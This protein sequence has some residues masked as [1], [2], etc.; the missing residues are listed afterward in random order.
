MNIMENNKVSFYQQVAQNL[1]EQLKQGTAPW[2]RAWDAAAPGTYLPMN[3][4]SGQRYR[5]IN[6]VQLLM[7]NRNDP[8]WLTYQQAAGQGGQVRKGEKGT[9]I[10]YWKF[11]EEK[12]QLDKQGKPVVDV[13]GNPIKEKI[14][15]ERPQV[16]YATV[17]NAEQIE[18]LRPLEKK[19]ERWDSQTKAESLLQASNATL[20]HSPLNG[21]YYHTATDRIYLP[22]KNQFPTVAHYYATALH[23][24]GH[25]T[26]HPARLA[27][28]LAHP[29]SSE[30]YAKEELR[31]EIASMILG[32]ELGIGYDPGNHVA[33]VKSWIKVLEENPHEIFRACADAEKIHDY[34]FNLEQTLMQTQEKD[35]V[36]SSPEKPSA[37]QKPVVITETD[38][39]FIAVPFSEKNIAQALGARWDRE[40]KSWYIHAGLDTSLFKV[41][42][43]HMPN[44]ITEEEKIQS[45]TYL[46]VPYE[47]RVAAKNVGAFWD[48]NEKSWCVAENF[49]LEKVKQWLPDNGRAE[50][51]PAM[52]VREEFT[53]ALKSAGCLVTDE[54]PIMDGQKHRIATE[55]DKKGETAGFYVVHVD[56]HPAGY[57]LN[58]R[59]GTEVKW[60]SK[61]YHFDPAQ[62]EQLQAEAA[63]KLQLRKAEQEKTYQ[64]TAERIQD[65]IAA[66]SALTSPTPY[67]KN[68]GVSLQHGLYTDA[69][70]S[71]TYIPVM[72]EN[73][74]QWSLQ[75]ID[76]HGAKRFEK[77][78]RKTGCFHPIGGLKALEKAPALVIAEG[79]ATAVS[80]TEALGYSAIAAFDAGNLE[81]VA[82]ALQ[83]KY[84]NKPIVIAGDDDRYLEATQSVNTG[85]VKALK[86]AEAVGGKV[87]FP[88]FTP[89][90]GE[91]AKKA[92]GFT[93]FNDVATKSVLG[94]KGLQR[95]VQFFVTQVIDNHQAQQPSQLSKK[96]TIYM[97][98]RQT[99]SV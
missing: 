72:D 38:K 9:V 18:G 32:D 29:F 60:K 17:F 94:F 67:L 97:Q 27:R 2:Q 13:D 10:Q 28:D 34:L 50:Q 55:G 6:S 61:G 59:T 75:I 53:A 84:P 89:E 65:K 44:K 92:K 82:K 1:I 49:D 22:E 62:K 57:I 21:P 23:E 31:A 99:L 74:K 51:A 3:P 20:N 39:I 87:M 45:R 86:A 46:A 14:L 85:K 36:F 26:G 35:K 43:Q 88:I 81:A 64:A 5:G 78:G 73:G 77:E 4:L 25:W 70:K 8:R 33:Y 80:L 40:K 68:K 41:W 11:T 90:E 24:L 71:R 54:H 52:S 30:G 91:Q 83:Q 69:E 76:E 37:T 16:F 95:Q 93:D 7:Q 15:L 79:Y 47:E 42:P 66:L 19:T 48:K 58:N 56:G 12:N 96:Q 98:Q 63:I